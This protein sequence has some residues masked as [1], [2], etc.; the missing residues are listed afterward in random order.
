M[1]RQ[2]CKLSFVELLQVVLNAGKGFDG[3]WVT[4][5]LRLESSLTSAWN[6]SATVPNSADVLALTWKRNHSHD[7]DG[8]ARVHD[9]A[10]VTHSIGAL[11]PTSCASKRICVWDDNGKILER[12]RA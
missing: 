8:V 4:C 5:S 12:N 3:L 2:G 11:L 1:R 10:S 7:D 6:K 9:L